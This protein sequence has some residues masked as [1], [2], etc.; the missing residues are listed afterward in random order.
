MQKRYLTGLIGDGLS[1]SLSPSLHDH[2]YSTSGVAGHYHAIDLQVLGT[3]LPTAVAS[4]KALGL[5]GFGVTHPYKEA[6]LPLLCPCPWPVP[7][8]RAKLC[9]ERGLRNKY[10]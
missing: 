3:D 8:A 7:L 1:K 4:A 2:A 10:R 9:V 5:R 6:V